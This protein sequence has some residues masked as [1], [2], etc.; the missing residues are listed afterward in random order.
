MK[1]D[2]WIKKKNLQGNAKI[3][4]KAKHTKT[5]GMKEVINSKKENNLTRN[6]PKDIGK[7]P[8]KIPTQNPTMQA[9]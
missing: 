2:E 8:Q 4:A 5:H 1:L 3:L 6:Q 7:K 9:D